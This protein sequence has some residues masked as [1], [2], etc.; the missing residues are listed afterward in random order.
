MH[1]AG[2]SYGLMAVPT[3]YAGSCSGSIL[4]AARHCCT[5]IQ[6]SQGKSVT[7][8]SSRKKF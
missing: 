5:A 7:A 1:L 2:T 8:S 4:A 3:S 6:P